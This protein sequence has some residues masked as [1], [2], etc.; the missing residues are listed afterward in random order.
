MSDTIAEMLTSIRNAQRAGKKEVLIQASNLKFAIAKVLEKEGFTE[1]VSREK[2]NDYEK[3]KIGLKYYKISSTKKLPAIKE[4]RKVSQQ[5]QRIY[6]KNKEI[7]DVRNKFGIAVVSTS[8][9]IMTNAE[10]K[11]NGLGGEYICEVW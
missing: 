7:K 6:V 9:G 10:A 4:I 2:I 1:S 3:I 11:K 8:K 5:G